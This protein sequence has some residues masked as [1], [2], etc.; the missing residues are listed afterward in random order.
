M[1][2][3]HWDRAARTLSLDPA[4]FRDSVRS[5]ATG[6]VGSFA[7]TLERVDVPGADDVR[8]HA[9]PRLERHVADL[10]A[11]LD[12]PPDPAPRN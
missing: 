3:R 5:M 1:L 10:V 12:D 8:V 2:G 11:R 7:E 6:F 4:R 9:M